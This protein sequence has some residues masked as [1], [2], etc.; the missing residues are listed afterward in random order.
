MDTD[1]NL[2]GGA[3][4]GA[5]SGLPTDA[6]RIRK[7]TGM[8]SGLGLNDYLQFSNKLR[9]FSYPSITFFL[10]GIEFS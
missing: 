3:G 1:R 10:T 7:S 8:L 2:T 9:H 6:D 4:F 5:L